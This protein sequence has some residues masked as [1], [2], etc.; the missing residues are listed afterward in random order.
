VK[1]ALPLT[2]KDFIDTIITAESLHMLK[3]HRI[4]K[5]EIKNEN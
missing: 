2:M 3:T 5:A 4:K 1:T